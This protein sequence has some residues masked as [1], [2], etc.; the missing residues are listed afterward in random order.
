MRKFYV[1]AM[2]ILMS[3]FASV[4]FAD[5]ARLAW[6]QSVSDDATG[7]RL[8][9]RVDNVEATNTF[10][11]TAGDGVDLGDVTTYVLDLNQFPEGKTYTFALTA[12]DAQGQESAYSEEYSWDRVAPQGSINVMVEGG[13]IKWT[14]ST[15]TDVGGY[16]IYW[17]TVAGVNLDGVNVGNILEWDPSSVM[18]NDGTYYFIVTAYDTSPDKNESGKSNEVSILKDT[19]A[20]EPPTNVNYSTE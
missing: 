2:F 8:Y 10:I 14:A 1:A 17:G 20:P 7:V 5:A 11:Q 16:N 13:L 6:D 3:I 9:W 4:S 15:S 19:V 12:Y 18:T